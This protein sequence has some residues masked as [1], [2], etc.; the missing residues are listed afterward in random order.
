LQFRP[1]TAHRVLRPFL[2]AYRVVSDEL[3]QLR[4][5]APFDEPAFLSRCLAR[6]KQYQL[7]RRIQSAES[8]SNVLFGTA[9]K[10][11]RNRGLLDAHGEK[12]GERRQAFAEELRDVIRRIDAVAALAAGRRAGVID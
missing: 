7:Q 2:E 12:L 8:V 6:G 1:F 11:A 5:D 4:A 10:L 9:L 3:E